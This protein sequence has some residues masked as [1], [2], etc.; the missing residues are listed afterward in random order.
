ME[1]GRKAQLEDATPQSSIPDDR[2]SLSALVAMI[3]CDVI[4]LVM[5]SACSPPAHAQDPAAN[6]GDVAGRTF[7][8]VV[9]MERL[10]ITVPPEELPSPVKGRW[11]RFEETLNAGPS[12]RYRVVESV[13]N[14][15]VRRACHESRPLNG[16]VTSGEFSLAGHAFGR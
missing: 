2:G 11:Q 7:G 16:C 1:T 6:A 10:T 13:T 9:P 5:L 8:A 15:G 14:D 4:L 12:R 3:A